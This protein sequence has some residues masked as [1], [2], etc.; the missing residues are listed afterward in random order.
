[1]KVFF[2]AIL[3]LMA[4]SS[5]AQIDLDIDLSNSSFKPNLKIN[6]NPAICDP[7]LEGYTSHF[8]EADS[9]S[10][11][12]IDVDGSRSNSAAHGILSEAFLPVSWRQIELDGDSRI[13]GL[14]DK[15]TLYAVS[16]NIGEQEK[17]LYRR[18]FWPSWR[19][20]VEDYYILDQPFNFSDYNDEEL[21][22]FLNN[23]HI[24]GLRQQGEGLYRILEQG[25][26]DVDEQD[27]TLRLANLYLFEDQVL[28]L[29]ELE[30]PI[31]RDQPDTGQSFGLFSLGS[32]NT[33]NQVC[34]IEIAPSA[35]LIDSSR[36]AIESLAPYANVLSDIMG[37]VSLC[38]ISIGPARPPSTMLDLLSQM[39]YRPWAQS[40]RNPLRP[41]S[42]SS[43]QVGE[44]LDRLF[45]MWGYSGLWNYGKYQELLLA[46]SVF[47]Q[48]LADYFQTEYSLDRASADE[49]STIAIL[50]FL[51]R[52]FV[53]T[54]EDEYHDLHR[55]LLDGGEVSELANFELP[56]EDKTS[57]YR[58]GGDPILV[59]AI[60]NPE[61]VSALL[62]AGFDPDAGNRFLKTPLMYAA[63]FDDLDSAKVLLDRG[64][65]INL[66]TT[67]FGSCDFTVH[68]SGN[69]AL[70]Y[71]ARYSGL[72]LVLTLLESGAH[73]AAQN[74]RGQT[75]HDYLLQ[76]YESR[77]GGQGALNER[78]SME[79]LELLIAR[80]T[81]PTE[82][83]RRQL[84]LSENLLGESLYQ[85]QKF[86]EAIE[87]FRNAILLNSEDTRAKNNFAV[88]ALKLG[89]YGES[90]LYSQQVI[91]SDG[92]DQVRAAA[93]FN[94]GLACEENEKAE[95]SYWASISYGGDAFCRYGYRESAFENFLRSYELYPTE[96]RANKIIEYLTEKNSVIG[97]R[98]CSTRDSYGQDVSYFVSE[99]QVIYTVLETSKAYEVPTISAYEPNR[100][101]ATA[102][103]ITF[104]AE[105][106]IDLGNNYRLVRWDYDEWLLSKNLIFDG[107]FVCTR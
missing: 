63:Q 59:Y 30:L 49:L 98:I 3:L 11:F 89:L 17:W 91:S 86:E 90:A 8:L 52:R 41:A 99:Q 45:M 7:L 96:S 56:L 87:H 36:G 64:A 10:P 18:S 97:K 51:S 50:S 76:D 54:I 104:V 95:N 57:E 53:T 106:L 25:E 46:E 4:K 35:T 37:D 15:G 24:V 55:F 84:S 47:E 62:D 85:E 83:E 82:D 92:S 27:R 20:E 33:V 13:T 103:E 102:E 93:Y 66:S 19:A 65:Q 69:T 21:R 73:T 58:G 80:L 2:A 79:D 14:F 16:F 12:E 39:L 77:S 6:H 101:Q 74:N 1:M 72:E 94:M 5:F 28:L 60:N 81:P 48:E 67:G 71:A 68:T 23:R 107:Y 75:P 61:L 105:S 29:F 32:N 70:H 88:T 44:Y 100:G 38:G 42:V 22:N 9:I 26:W 78:L 34:E 40:P 43:D 31:Y